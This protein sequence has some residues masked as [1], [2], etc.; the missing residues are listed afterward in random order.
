MILPDSKELRVTQWIGVLNDGREAARSVEQPH[1]GSHAL[2]GAR[3]FAFA[4]NR[5]RRQAYSKRADVGVA[6]I[7]KS[8]RAG[9]VA[10]TWGRAVRVC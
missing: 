10:L 2:R 5:D 9:V 4:S 1:E 8:R 7:P 6:S 3:S